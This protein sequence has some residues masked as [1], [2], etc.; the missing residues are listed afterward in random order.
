MNSQPSIPI[1]AL[2]EKVWDTGELG[3]L[4]STLQHLTNVARRRFEADSWASFALNHIT[5]EFVP[6]VALARENGR[7]INSTTLSGLRQSNFLKPL[8]QDRVLAVEDL[9]LVPQ[10]QDSFAGLNDVQ[11]F[12]AVS[13]LT[14]QLRKPLA[15]LYLNFHKPRRF[16]ENDREWLRAFADQASS[17]LQNSWLLHR[18]REI[19]RMGQEINQEFGSVAALFKKLQKQVVQILDISH[20]FML[21]IYRGQTENFDLYLSEQGQYRSLLDNSLNGGYS[22][23][24]QQ[25]EPLL[26]RQLSRQAD[27]LPVELETIPGTDPRDREA[28]IFVPLILEG[29]PLGLLSV[30]HPE[31]GIYS[32]NDLHILRLLGSYVSSALNNTRIFDD[33][34]ELNKTG[35]LLT[36]NLGSTQVLQHV[37]DQIRLTTKADLAI[38]YPYE[39]ATQQFEL[40]PYLSGDLLKPRTLQPDAARSGNLVTS[41]LHQN[42]VIFAED[43]VTLYQ[44]L[45]HKTKPKK[46]SFVKREKI[47]AAAVVPLRV[48]NDVV[49]ILFINFR[50]P[51]RFD[52][53]S[54]QLIRSLGN[55]AAI[56]IKNAREFKALAV[57]RLQELEILRE[58]DQAIGQSLDLQYVLQTILYL[59]NDHVSLDKGVI[60]LYDQGTE[61][62][63]KEAA[64]GR[65]ANPSLG[66]AIPLDQEKGITRWVFQ[67]KKPVRIGN[68]H[69][70]PHWRDTYLAGSS[71]ILSELDVPLLDGDDVIGVINLESTLENA[72]SQVDE[73]FMQTLAGQAVLAIKN[74]KA[75]EIQ[76]Y[77]LA[78]RQAL[79]QIGREII[80]QLE[81]NQV[82]ELILE[83]ALEITGSK[84]GTLMLFDP[85][86]KDLWMAAERG[87]SEEQKGRRHS[88]DEGITGWVARNKQLLNVGDI[89]QPPWDKVHLPFIAN[90]RAELTV[91]LLEANNLKGILNLES[92]QPNHFDEG[93]ERLL[94]ELADLAVITLQNADRYQKVKANRAKL[95]ALREVDHKIISQLDNHDQVMRAILQNTVSLT[96]AELVSLYL[97]DE[98]RLSNIYRSRLGDNPKQE[99][100]IERIETPRLPGEGIV[101]QVAKT[102]RSY[103]TLGDAQADPYYVGA[104]DIR[105]EV[106]VPLL[107]EGETLIGILN[108]ESLRPYAFDMEDVWLLEMFG[109]QAVIAIQ[110]A[111]AYAQAERRAHRFQLLHEAARKLGEIKHLSEIEQAY[112]IVTQIAEK[113]SQNQMI[114]RRYDPDVGELVLVRTAPWQQT[115]AV[116]R[117]KATDQGVSPQVA[118]ERR[119]L[120]VSDIE[121]PPPGVANPEPSDPR[122]RSLIVTPIQIEDNYYGNLGVTYQKTRHFSDD[123]IKLIE[124]LAQQLAITINRLEAVLAQQEAEQRATQ[125][126][127]MGSIGESAYELT[128]RLGNNLGLI[129]TYVNNVHLILEHQ[130][131]VL[132]TEVTPELDKIVRDVRK[133]LNLSKR[134]KEELANFS[135]GTSTPIP[136]KVLVEEAVAAF[137]HLPPNIQLNT[138]TA[139]D[140]ARVQAVPGHIKDILYNLVVN[141]IEAMPTGGIITFRARNA[142]RF[143]AFEVEDTGPGI[144]QHKQ[145]QIFNLFFSTKGS[146]GFGLWSARRKA[147]AQG[148]DLQV[149][150]QPDQ[151]TTFILL[152]PRA[153][154]NSGG[155]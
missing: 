27:H 44:T 152:L 92:P 123:D 116:A 141:A 91:P 132:T 45:Y 128:H 20:F 53:L 85:R 126:E 103:I 62:L 8:L 83:K 12:I 147:L 9:E 79:G 96:G 80:G 49:G 33:L 105:S 146:S 60:L 67:Y 3:D 101:N 104:P 35:Q 129:Q 86:R 95:E 106:A 10:Y 73:E 121:H 90:T 110:N 19:T 78:E 55:Y 115:P 57:R 66:K 76:K 122:T 81:L 5:E 15:L 26:I 87:V 124:G 111:R 61:T 68:V 17:I 14:K 56:A 29:V 64:I 16:S 142:N 41:A 51:Q 38:L 50:Q 40:P 63:I 108:L 137:P 143:V 13:L 117:I 2:L 97:Y 72:F 7:E 52:G 75:Y 11:S 145:A 82:F 77:L 28:L 65:N 107:A 46:G 113:Y 47:Q 43:N 88:L 131:D 6:S 23:V 127:L 31:P 30:Q 118:R 155:I 140:L 48:I 102:Q 93:D 100:S 151:G 4:N 153:I 135:E 119:T 32:Q 39:Q 148:G 109:G 54:Q 58:I 71:D 1:S 21:A 36:Q 139:D 154:G 138:E 136:A 69:R 37:V 42:Q 70:D 24:L 114:I 98:D 130:P 120:V 84:A 18:F 59:A 144:P 149:K 134:L 89:A 125:A 74:A 25:Q 150:S 99:P 133:V 22:W 34:R 112:D 94:S